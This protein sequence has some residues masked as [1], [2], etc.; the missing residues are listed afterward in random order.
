MSFRLKQ[1]MLRAS[2]KVIEESARVFRA[3]AAKFDI[4]PDK[5]RPVLLLTR[6]GTTACHALNQLQEPG[7]RFVPIAF[8]VLKAVVQSALTSCWRPERLR[9]YLDLRCFPQRQVLKERSTVPSAPSVACGAIFSDSNGAP[10]R[11]KAERKIPHWIDV[12]G[13]CWILR[14]H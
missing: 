11:R 10:H 13:I 2:K 14:F 12:L 1:N 7:G 8:W 6:R 5:A 9:L 4:N 3:Y